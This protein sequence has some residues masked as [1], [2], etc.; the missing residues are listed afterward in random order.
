MRL[1]RRLR[2]PC[3]PVASPHLLLLLL[4]LYHAPFSSR[5]KAADRSSVTGNLGFGPSDGAR[6]HGRAPLR[7]RRRPSPRSLPGSGVPGVSDLGAAALSGG[8]LP[9]LPATGTGVPRAIRYPIWSPSPLRATSYRRSVQLYKSSIFLM[10]YLRCY[11][12]FL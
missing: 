12:V 5:R 2:C 3:P 10:V 1:R 8:R 7:W 4:L 6:P 11:L 9:S